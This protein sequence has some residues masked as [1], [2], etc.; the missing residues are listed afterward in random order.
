MTLLTIDNLSISFQVQKETLKAVRGI[1]LTLEKGEIVGLVGESGCGKSVTAKSILNLIGHPGRI[2]QGEVLYN[3]KNLL[4][5]SPEELRAV[6]G[7]SIAM[8]FQNPVGALNP[9]FSIKTQLIDVIRLHQKCTKKEAYDKAIEL[10]T[11]VGISDP[12]K[13]ING[14]PHQ[15]SGGMAQRVMIAMAISSTPDIII[16]DE[17]TAS[18]DVTIQ[19]QITDL[20]RQLS[21]NLQSSVLMISHDLS[22][23]KQLCQRIYVM[24]LGK[25]VEEGPIEQV[26]N[27]PQHPYTKL[28][29]SSAGLRKL[30]IPYPSMNELP[31]PLNL[32]QGCSFQSRCPYVEERCTLKEPILKDRE[33]KQKSACV[34]EF[35]SVSSVT[36]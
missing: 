33:N 18:L 27:N 10:L 2:D 23:I 36:Q 1:S 15:F 32:P 30:E 5:C 34:L 13:R 26:F 6:R 29:L 19:A 21:K 28:L 17:P 31:S 14:Y 25:I 35:P 9:V 3:N 20:L 4:T 22:V 11:Q 16:A 7:K 24:Y 8:I 12:E